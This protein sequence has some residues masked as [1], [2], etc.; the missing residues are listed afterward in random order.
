MAKGNHII[1]L[2]A[3]KTLA[4]EVQADKLKL[5][6]QDQAKICKCIIFANVLF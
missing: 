4:K 5:N 3:H 1:D 6:H 2:Q